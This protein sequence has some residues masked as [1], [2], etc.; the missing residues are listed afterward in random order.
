MQPR[1]SKPYIVSALSL[2]AAKAEGGPRQMTDNLSITKGML[3]FL[4]PL[5]RA[6]QSALL[7]HLSDLFIAWAEMENRVIFR[8][9][10]D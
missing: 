2:Q 4:I 5:D 9:G 1:D 3:L 6:L 10:E 8:A 7:L